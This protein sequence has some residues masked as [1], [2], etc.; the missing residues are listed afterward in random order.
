MARKADVFFSIRLQPD[1]RRSIDYLR[2]LAAEGC[3]LRAA[4]SPSGFAMPAPAQ[5]RRELE[6]PSAAERQ[7]R[8]TPSVAPQWWLRSPSSVWPQSPPGPQSCGAL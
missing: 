6:F 4:H 2:L 1:V 8:V 7:L 3:S 5:S